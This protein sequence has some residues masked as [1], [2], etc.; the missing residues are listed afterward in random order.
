MFLQEFIIWNCFY[1]DYFESYRKEFFIIL[2]GGLIR[3]NNLAASLTFSHILIMFI[4]ITTFVMTGG[5]LT[6]RRVF[7]TLS[8]VAVMKDV[9][10][11]LFER[12]IFYFSE[13][14]VGDS[15]IQVRLISHGSKLATP[16]LHNGHVYQGGGVRVSVWTR[17][18]REIKE[19][20]KALLTLWWQTWTSLDS[21]E[22]SSLRQYVRPFCPTVKCVCVNLH[23]IADDL[24]RP[25]T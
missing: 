22:L 23:W 20:S 5:T 3:A 25:I 21:G 7:T 17:E 18:Q 6:P 10:L 4:T 1:L 16:T 11:F 13:S 12:G 9:M 2:R 14:R 24:L 19:R 15:R 8:L